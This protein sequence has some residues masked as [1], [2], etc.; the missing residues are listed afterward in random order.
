V[1]PLLDRQLLMQVAVVALVK[2]VA[3]PPTQVVEQVHLMLMQPLEPQ[4]QVVVAV[5][6]TPTM[7]RQELMVAV[8]VL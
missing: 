6:T 5:E 4:T 8:L 1:F 7:V 3:E 2:V